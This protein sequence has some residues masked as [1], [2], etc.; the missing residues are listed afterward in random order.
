MVLAVIMLVFSG[1]LYSHSPGHQ[2]IHATDHGQSA[3]EHRH[4][5]LS[6][7]Y[8]RGIDSMLHCGADILGDG[9]SKEILDSNWRNL[10]YD[11]PFH[12]LNAYHSWQDPP[13]PRFTS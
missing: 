1:S 4:L 7:A 11:T 13:P 3:P 6:D 5:Q 2:H 8:Q 9:G 10:K 12:I